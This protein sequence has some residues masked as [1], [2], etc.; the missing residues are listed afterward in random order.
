MKFFFTPVISFYLLTLTA[1]AQINAIVTANPAT[2]CQGNTSAMSASPTGTGYS[3]QWLLN[4]SPINGA[5]N[6]VYSTMIGGSFSCIVTDGIYTDTSNAVVITVNPN[7]VV[8]LPPNST[9]C[10]GQSVNLCVSGGLT[11]QWSN[12][13]VTQ[14]ITVGTAGAYSVTVTDMNGCT[15]SASTV[16]TVLP[17]P[18]ATISGTFTIC[19]GNSASLTIN[20]TGIPPFTYSYTNG[21]TTFGPFTTSNTT[22]TII[23]T[24]FTTTVY[25]LTGVSNGACTGT[26]NGSAVVTVDPLPFTVITALGATTFCVGDSVLLTAGGGFFSYQWMRNSSPIPGATSQNYYAK[27]KGNYICE[28]WNAS[29]S[30]ISNPIHVSVPCVP[31]DPPELKTNMAAGETSNAGIVEISKIVSDNM[32]L[33][34]PVS[35][36]TLYNS[37]GILLENKNMLNAQSTDIDFKNYAP[38][39]YFLELKTNAGNIKMKVFKM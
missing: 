38:G 9:I 35:S 25:S 24:P 17:L 29:C 27:L 1:N 22:E 39:F 16:I 26:V 21:S 14:C 30:N 3:Y 13:A 2:M 7:P 10:A 31:I 6:N 4:N 20:F 12:G 19:I 36:Y 5:I 18:M 23:V 34:F 32:L 28:V 37:S 33:N 8:S 15:G 11:F